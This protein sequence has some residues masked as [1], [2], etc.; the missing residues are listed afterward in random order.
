MGT[1]E[2]WLRFHDL[3]VLVRVAGFPEGLS[4]LNHDFRY[5]VSSAAARPD[6]VVTLRRGRL[7]RKRGLGVGRSRFLRWRAGES[8]VLFF[9]KTWVRYRFAR[10]E[11]EIV[12]TSAD[13]AYEALYLVLLSAVG[14]SLDRRG[15][16][17]LHGFAFQGWGKGLVLLGRSGSGKSTLGMELLA[18]HPVRLVS[19][20]TPLVSAGGTMLCFP[21]RIASREP[22]RFGREHARRFR[23]FAHPEKHVVSMDALEGRIADRSSVDWLV[24]L[25]EGGPSSSPRLRRAGRATALWPLVKWLVVGYE[26]PQIWELFLRPSPSDVGRKIG[27]ALSRAR[28]AWRLWRGARVAVLER[29]GSP[30]ECVAAMERFFEGSA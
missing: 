27:I 22:P 4:D 28:A 24:L 23:R 9:G 21:Q 13:E 29:A 10:G 11:A 3:A 17:R 30:R 18:R 25:R 20:D 16:H 26:T 2:R 5:F 15:L 7:P 19:D 1:E 6:L 14:E 12:G 8:Q